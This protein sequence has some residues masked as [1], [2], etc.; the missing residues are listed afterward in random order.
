MSSIS[1]AELMVTY[2]YMF[3]FSS[4]SRDGDLLDGNGALEGYFDASLLH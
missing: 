1:F 2:L 4:S 3:T